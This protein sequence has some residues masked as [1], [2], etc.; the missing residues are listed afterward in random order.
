MLKKSEIDSE[1]YGA[2]Y[3]SP[4]REQLKLQAKV[5]DMWLFFDEVARSLELKENGLDDADVLEAI[6][7]YTPAEIM[8]RIYE[9][10]PIEVAAICAD[11]KSNEGGNIIWPQLLHEAYKN[12]LDIDDVWKIYNEYRRKNSNR[13]N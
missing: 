11:F 9:L 10:T 4:R 5:K 12:G 1:L 6:S 7:D 2:V 8:L 13:R 3:K